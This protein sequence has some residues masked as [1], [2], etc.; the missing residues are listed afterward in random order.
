ML[1]LLLCC[2]RVHDLKPGVGSP[3][4]EFACFPCAYMGSLWCASSHSSQT[5]ML[6]LRVSLNCS[7]ECAAWLFVR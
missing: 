5:C 2:K 4:I 7:I 1:A 3:G 6:G